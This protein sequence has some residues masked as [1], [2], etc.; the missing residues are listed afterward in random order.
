MTHA[1]HAKDCAVNVPTNIFMCARHWRM[2]P[3]PLQ[4]AIGD[5]WSMG[6]GSPYRENCDEAIRIVGEAEGLGRLLKMPEFEPGMKALT[7]WQPWASLV[8]ILAKPYEFRKWSFADKPNL[9]RLVGQ[10]I[11]IHAGARMPREA[12]LEDILERIADGDS[13]LLPNAGQ[14]IEQQLRQLRATKKIAAPVSAA[15]G[16]AIIGEP[17]KAA[18]LFADRVADSDRIDHQMYAWPLTQI[19]QFEEPIPAHGAQGFWNWS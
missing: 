18:K 11:V 17:V 10:R 12:E 5:G 1:C 8:I 4:R 6:G 2:V 13:A 7:I 19:R 3:K 9:A 16:T 15:L 14:F